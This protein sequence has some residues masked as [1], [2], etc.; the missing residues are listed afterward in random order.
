ML[1]IY[2]LQV[3][4]IGRCQKFSHKMINIAAIVRQT[5]GANDRSVFPIVKKECKSLC[6]IEVNHCTVLTK[7]FETAA[8]TQ[9][10]N[11]PTKTPIESRLTTK[12]DR[13]LLRFSGFFTLHSQIVLQ[14]SPV[15][16]AL[17]PIDYARKDRPV[18]AQ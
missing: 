12:I 10:K 2:C 18:S 11:K 9:P 14:P 15:K 16:F 1:R 7:K 8:I 13:S 4:A 3:R 6:L 5:T 17:V